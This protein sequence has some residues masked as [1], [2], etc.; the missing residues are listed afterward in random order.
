MDS[1][2]SLCNLNPSSPGMRLTIISLFCEI[3]FKLL[4]EHLRGCHKEARVMLD[5]FQICCFKV[6]LFCFLFCTLALIKGL[7]LLKVILPTCTH[8]DG[9]CHINIF[10]C[11]CWQEYR[12]LET[13]Y[14][15][16]EHVKL[17]IH[18]GNCMLPQKNYKENCHFI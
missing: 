14:T 8:Q 1:S 15:V 13:P 3:F 7:I 12:E 17:C 18:Y 9:Y 4:V 6:E 16:G 10:L 2:F 11:L 5:L